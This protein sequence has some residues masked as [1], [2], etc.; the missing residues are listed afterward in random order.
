MET[1]KN[2]RY[3]FT[4]F[5]PAFNR[6]PTL[7]RVYESLRRQ[8]FRDFEWLIVDDGST[9]GTRK[10]VEKWQTE[11]GF[12]IRYIYQENRGKPTAFNRGVREAQGELF[13]T[14]DSDDACLPQALERF[15]YHWDGISPTEKDKFS[16]VTVLCKDQN[17]R[18]VGDKFPRDVL[19]SDSIELFFKYNVRGEK[20]GF[21]RTDVL[22]E[23]PFPTVRNEKFVS[24]GVVWFALSR[25]FKTRFVNE[26]LR[27]YHMND[28]AGD[29]LSSL[30]PAVL[31]GRALFHKYVLNELIDWCF[32]SPVIMLRSAT[33]FS[34]Y[35]FGLGKGPYSQFKEL[36]H[37]ASRLLVAISLPLAFAMS[38]KDKRSVARAGRR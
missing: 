23:F 17:G 4:V 8:T 29:R 31:F 2:Y 11:S 7:P 13:L 15:K 21:H 20:W 10:L 35:S 24:E 27:I 3:V 18:L 37:L 1:R 32:S 14:L 16:A 25:R 19:D 34:R 33:N 28:K 9:D 38:L 30:S 22:K 26:V 5:T 12:P 6:A 36:C